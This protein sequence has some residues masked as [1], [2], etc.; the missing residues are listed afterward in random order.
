MRGIIRLRSLGAQP[1]ISLDLGSSDQDSFLLNYSYACAWF[2]N[3][4][5]RINYKNEKSKL[6][7][8]KKIPQA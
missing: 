7:H 3:E 8:G 2:R 1:M 4:T 6:L 5:E